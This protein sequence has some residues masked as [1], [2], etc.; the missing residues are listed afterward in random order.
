M[1]ELTK[2]Q[3]D[4]LGDRLRKGSVTEVDLRFLDLYHRSFAEAYETVVGSIRQR[5]GLGPTGRPAKSTTSISEKLRR[6]SIRLTQMQGIAG[7]RLLV[8]DVADQERVVGALS[9]LFDDVTIIDRRERPS[10]GYRAVHLIVTSYGKV[11]EKQ[12]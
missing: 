4:R 9:R 8:S 7:C 5:L 11:I 10:Y 6:E 2:T 12:V 1:R 3:L